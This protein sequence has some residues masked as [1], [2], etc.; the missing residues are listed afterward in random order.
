MTP[1]EKELAPI[2][3]LSTETVDFG[4]L[5]PESKTISRTFTIT[6]DGKKPLILRRLFTADPAISLKLKSDRIKPGKS[7]T[8]TVSVDCSMLT[9]GNP[10]NGRIT[11]I[12]N[13]PNAPSQTIRVIGEVY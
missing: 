5:S 4:R 13:S 1:E 6:N 12:A 9:A 11:L 7:T 8:V 3:S 2:A 10:L